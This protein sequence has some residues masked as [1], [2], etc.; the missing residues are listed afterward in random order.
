MED[1]AQKEKFIK[2]VEL[3]SDVSFNDNLVSL[4]FDLSSTK[5]I[6]E[7]IEV[8]QALKD[9]KAPAE[10]PNYYKILE[11]YPKDENGTVVYW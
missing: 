7:K 6:D 4:F 3:W 9:G 2:M 1:R 8:L 5:M 11:N 10:I